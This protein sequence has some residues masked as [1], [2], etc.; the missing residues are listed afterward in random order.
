MS[1]RKAKDSNQCVAVDI[2]NKLI[3][4]LWLM[5]IMRCCIVPILG[6]RQSSS[7]MAK[8]WREI[9]IWICWPECNGS[10]NSTP[11]C[12]VRSYTFRV[13][14]FDF[15]CRVVFLLLLLLPLL[16]LPLPPFCSP[17][18]CPC[19]CLWCPRSTKV[20]HGSLFLDPTRP[21][22]TLT[23]PAIANKKSGPTRPDP[24]RGPSLPP[25]VHSLIE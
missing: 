6:Y 8:K 1:Q 12:R 17:Y 7:I 25:Y 5:W 23:W 15:C 10:F 21:G 16:L 24:T 18:C 13:Q 19:C 14:L 22:E 4:K 9:L 3:W 11:L 2:N 20:V